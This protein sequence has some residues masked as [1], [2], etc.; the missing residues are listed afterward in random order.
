MALD[1]HVDGQGIYDLYSSYL[2]D[3][4]EP[5]DI[6]MHDNASVHTAHIVKELLREQ[7][8]EVMDWPPFSPDLNPTE[9]LWALM[10]AKIYQIDPTLLH[11]SDTVAS[12]QQLRE[13]A[14]Q[15][16]H[17]IG[18]DVHNKLC[19]TIENRVAAVLE[20]DGWYTKY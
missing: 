4:L 15:A 11:I 13:V 17:Q 12:Y 3:F 19:E 10:K 9:N 2:P 16:W 6:F 5:D 18:Q 7:G 1:G 20:A 14:K 8:F